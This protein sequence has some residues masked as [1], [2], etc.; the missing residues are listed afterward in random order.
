VFFE[1]TEITDDQSVAAAVRSS[2]ERGPLRVAVNCVGYG[3]STPLLSADG[4]PT[5][6]ESFQEVID[7]NLIGAIN[8]MRHEAAA[9]AALPADEAGQRGVIINVSSIAGL[10]GAP[11]LLA[12]GAAKAGLDAITLPA[13]RQL[14]SHGIRVMAIAPGYFH[15]PPWTAA[16]DAQRAAAVAGVA[17]PARLGQP[18]EFAELVQH[19]VE[20]RYL[21]GTSIRID[22]GARM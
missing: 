18:S 21:N 6:L 1:P 16:T 4:L 20:N 9:M 17:G 14:G 19:I 2:T 8:S 11:S 22:A 3:Q 13:A 7:V 5:P 12:Y 15:T 10:D